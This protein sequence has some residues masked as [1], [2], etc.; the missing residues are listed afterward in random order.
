MAATP[1]WTKAGRLA[2]L[3]EF[4]RHLAA[5]RDQEDAGSADEG[6]F[7]TQWLRTPSL[8]EFS[9]LLI[10]GVSAH[11]A[12][13]DDRIAAAAENWSVARMAAT[14]RNLLRLGCYEIHHTDTPV[15]VAIDEAVELAKRFGGAQSAQFVNGILDKLM[16]EKGEVRSQKSGVRMSEAHRLHDY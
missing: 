10:D 3:M 13:L 16:H 4:V 14:D 12:E 1:C 15:K 8:V 5:L 6:E 11:R 9:R 7:Y 2:S